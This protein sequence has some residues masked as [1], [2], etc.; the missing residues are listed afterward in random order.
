MGELRPEQ[1][2]ISIWKSKSDAGGS[3]TVFGDEHKKINDVIQNVFSLGLNAILL[4][5]THKTSTEIAEQLFEYWRDVP[6][7]G[8]VLVRIKPATIKED[9]ARYYEILGK[10]P[11]QATFVDKFIHVPMIIYGNLFTRTLR[12][13]HYQDYTHSVTLY[14]KN[15]SVGMHE[16]GHAIDF[17]PHVALLKRTHKYKEKFQERGIVAQL[18][19]EWRASA[20]AMKHLRTDEERRMAMKQLEPAYGTYVG[21]ALG[22]VASMA[23]IAGSA[24]II[25]LNPALIPA[26]VLAFSLAGKVGLAGLIGIDIMLVARSIGLLVGVLGAKIASALKNR[27]SSFGYVFGDV[28]QDKD[29]LFVGSAR[30]AYAL[31][32]TK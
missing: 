14:N 26:H 29:V 2:K 28:R 15:F 17:D 1:P 21:D 10:T 13:S 24:A 32:R 6:W 20:N 31:N 8:N 5:N 3:L 30:P 19:R 22:K 16:L 7:K 27:R 23:L 25:A 12:A 9:I 18:K 4:K 11:R